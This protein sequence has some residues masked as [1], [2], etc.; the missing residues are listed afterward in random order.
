MMVKGVEINRG[1]LPHISISGPLGI[2][3]IRGTVGINPQIHHSQWAIKITLT[4]LE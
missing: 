3:H 2:S 4:H 1:E